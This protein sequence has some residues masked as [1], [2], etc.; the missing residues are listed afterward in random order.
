MGRKLRQL[1][2]LR[3]ALRKHGKTDQCLLWPYSTRGQMGYGQVPIGNGKADSVHRV[4]WRELHGEIPE[5]KDVMHT[6]DTPRCFAEKHLVLGT[7]LDN[8][9]D[10]AKK[11]RIPGPG[12]LVAGEKNG[13][14][15][16]TPAQ[17][18]K[19]RER[20]AQGWGL[21]PLARSF[22]VGRTTVQKIIQGK[23]WSH[24]PAVEKES[25]APS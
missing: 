14:A 9:Q 3:N 16:L 22:G 19:I 20:H 2:F 23:L 10:A 11:G 7:R 6:C 21:R 13:R 1:E 8:M 25:S 12:K 24:L 5:G 17:V 18:M 4:A 15:V